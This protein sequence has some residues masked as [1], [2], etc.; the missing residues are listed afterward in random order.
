VRQHFC[1]N[2]IL[3]VLDNALRLGNRI[4]MLCTYVGR[5][6]L[7]F[8]HLNFNATAQRRNNLNAYTFVHFM[9]FIEHE[10]SC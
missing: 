9:P 5:A 7:W 4:I 10:Y 3:M 8:C 1:E 2:Y 6:L